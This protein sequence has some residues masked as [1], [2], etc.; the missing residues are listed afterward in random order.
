VSPVCPPYIILE[1]VPLLLSGPY[2]KIKSNATGIGKTNCPLS[3][4]LLVK[5]KGLE[6]MGCVHFGFGA[7]L[8][9]IASL[10]L[11]SVCLWI[12]GIVTLRSTS[13]LLYTLLS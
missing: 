1:D 7:I 9:H 2:Q 3:I 4:W 11:V 12:T 6:D 10:S 13:I 8:L 5:D